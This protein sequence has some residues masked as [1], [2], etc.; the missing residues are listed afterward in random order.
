M[1][2]FLSDLRYSK[3]VIFHPFDA[4]YELKFRGRGNT[5][6]ATL[7]YLLLGITAI[8]NIQFGGFLVTFVKLS[9]F[10][11]AIVFTSILTPYIFFAIGNYSITTLMDGKGR[12]GEIYNV[13]GYSLL[14]N[15]IFLFSAT[16]VSNFITMD[17]LEFYT[18]FI[19]AGNG[20]TLFLIFV[21]LTVTH[22]YTFFRSLISIVLSFV[23]VTLII[24][25]LLL[26]ITLFSQLY[27]FVQIVITEL[28]N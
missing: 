10:N 14:P 23:A 3:E 25:I 2:T 20:I 6:V 15:I 19:A 24:F 16:I 4:F 9:E 17:E 18:L 21:G 7:F 27:G 28:R 13:I 1:T 22:E 26:M 12:F 11:S 8:I 5:L